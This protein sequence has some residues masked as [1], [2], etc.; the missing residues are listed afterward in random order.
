MKAERRI[1]AGR[2]E[3]DGLLGR[4]GMA[5]V[6][7]A[8]DRVL[9]RSVAVKVLSSRLAE[10]RA[11]VERFRREARAA[12]SLNHPNVV[13]IFDTG[14]EGDLH[15]I[16]MEYVH[17]RTLADVLVREGRLPVA[18]VLEIGEAVCLALSFAHREGLVHRDVKPGNIMLTDEGHV[19]LTDFGIARATTSDT[20][21][22]TAMVMGTA[23][24]LSPEQARG[25]R[26]DARSDVYS[27]GVV[28][29]E[30]VTGTPPFTGDS[31]LA[32]AYQHLHADRVPASR[33]NPECPPEL[34]ALIERAMAKEPDRRYQ[35][36]DD[37]ARD[38]ARV[39]NGEVITA[40]AAA[41]VPASPAGEPPASGTEVIPR[42]RTQVLPGQPA[43]RT[44][45]PSGRRSRSQWVGLAVILGIA[46]VALALFV[47]FAPEPGGET[48]DTPGASGTPRSA[49]P[50]TATRQSPQPSSPGPTTAAPEASTSVAQAVASL[51]S[52]LDEGVA[53]GEIDEQVAA[54]IAREIDAA[55]RGYERGE[56]D[57]ALEALAGAHDLVDS[58]VDVGRITTQERADAI[59]SAIDAVEEAMRAAPIEG[60]GDGGNGNEGEGGGD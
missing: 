16:V 54:A 31:P 8:T 13:G 27:L 28:L 36:A 53:A 29:H 2:Y 55:L 49:P 39:R 42:D 23:A 32:V 26:V 56:L 40:T 15:F 6:Y 20:V 44:A 35:K 52:V 18:R 5:E 34:D 43:G 24:Y 14:S 58:G 45:G 22:Q 21:T 47:M 60:D 7:R 50:A 11:F 38:L 10:D 3:T 17:G 46:A 59:H 19:K 37:L 33:T 9:G 51:Q 4:G 57:R 1:F 12:A 48:D 41:P 25:E 30:A